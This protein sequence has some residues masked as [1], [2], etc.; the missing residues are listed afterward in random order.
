MK[1]IKKLSTELKKRH[2][3]SKNK[4][5]TNQ[6]VLEGKKLVE[7]HNALKLEKE[8]IKEMMDEFKFMEGIDTFEKFKEFILTSNYWADTWAVSTLEKVLNIKIIILSKESY[9]ADDLDSVLK[10]GQLNDDALEKQGKFMPDYYIMTSYSGNHY[11]LISYKKKRILK[12]S[13]IPYD[14]KSL[15]VNKCMER[16]AGPYYLIQD[17]RNL[18]SKLGLSPDEGSPV[19]EE[20][21][22]NDYDLY[23]SDIV[24][25]F[26]SKS[27]S[28]PKAGKGSGEKIPESKMMEFNVLNKDKLCANWRRKLDDSWITPF[29]VEGHSWASVDHYVLGSQFKK[30][31]PD[32]YSQFSLDSL[33]EISKDVALAKAAGGKTGKLKDKVLR[34][35]HVRVDSDFY[36]VG[37]N[38]RNEIERNKALTAKFSQNLD[39]KK[40]LMETKNAKLVKFIRSS[41]PSIDIML[42]NLRKGFMM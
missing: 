31:F 2:E 20:E 28:K 21:E 25:E 12:F 29:T 37:L 7:R 33:S 13:E 42:M 9:D 34:P 40:V 41:P 24:F 16:N 14:I 1:E 35:K 11:E 23:D 22:S 6:I 38:P 8:D 19:E 10:C 5:E 27:D 18:K 30:G 17:F 4:E 15:V 36:E 3:R 26:H 39:L 32:F